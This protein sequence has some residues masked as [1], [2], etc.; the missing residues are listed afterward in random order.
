MS[1]LLDIAQFYSQ[2]SKRKIDH[3]LNIW[4]SFFDDGEKF[5]DCYRH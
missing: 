5:E 3:I 2:L 1:K 4:L